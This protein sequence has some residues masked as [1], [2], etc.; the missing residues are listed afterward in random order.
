MGVGSNGNV[1]LPPEFL[2]TSGVALGWDLHLGALSL[3]RGLASSGTIDPDQSPGDLGVYGG[4]LAD[5]WDRDGD[6]YPEWW[7]PGSYDATAYPAAGWDCDDDD[8]S[9]YPGSGC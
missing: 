5:D 7:Q 1:S 2:A 9:V 8:S 6:G 4:P 3:L